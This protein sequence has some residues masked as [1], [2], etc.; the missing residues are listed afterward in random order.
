[1]PPLLPLCCKN[2]RLAERDTSGLFTRVFEGTCPVRHTY[3]N[4]EQPDTTIRHTAVTAIR[5]RKLMTNVY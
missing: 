4:P 1:M 5:E 3:P 2:K